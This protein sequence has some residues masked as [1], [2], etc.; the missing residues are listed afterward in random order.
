MPHMYTYVLVA[1]DGL[2]PRPARAVLVQCPGPPPGPHPVLRLA[3]QMSSGRQRVRGVQVGQDERAK[4]LGQNG[5][6]ASRRHPLPASGPGINLHGWPGFLRRV[7]LKQLDTE[8]SVRVYVQ[9]YVPRGKVLRP[10]QVLSLAGRPT[11]APESRPCE[12]W[13][14]HPGRPTGEW[15][16]RYSPR[17]VSPARCWTASPTT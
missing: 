13:R 12:D 10:Y 1:L 15:R 11:S 7:L 9:R 4:V 14:E 17:S 3:C 6:G 5:R 16:P 8:S 2:A